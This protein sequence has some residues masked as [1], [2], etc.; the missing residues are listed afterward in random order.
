[1]RVTVIAAVSSLKHLDNCLLEGG[2]S[3]RAMKKETV[4]VLVSA[5]NNKV[6]ALGMREKERHKFNDIEI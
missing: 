4:R 5:L 6:E 2:D 3:Q 1:M